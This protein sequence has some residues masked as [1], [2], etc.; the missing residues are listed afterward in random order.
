MA[1]VQ[2]ETYHTLEDSFWVVPTSRLERVR[3]KELT[4]GKVDLRGIVVFFTREEAETAAD[5]LEEG[6][7]SS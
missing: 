3:M 4:K 2:R 7:T 6:L 5:S 1:F